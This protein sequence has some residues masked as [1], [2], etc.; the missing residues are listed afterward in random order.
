MLLHRPCANGLSVS[1]L[2]AA[3]STP[4]T[5]PANRS[6]VGLGPR[7]PTGIYQAQVGAKR[8]AAGGGGRGRAEGPAGRT[9]RGRPAGSYATRTATPLA[10]WLLSVAGG[11]PSRASSPHPGMWYGPKFCLPLP[12]RAQSWQSCRGAEVITTLAPF[13][14]TGRLRLTEARRFSQDHTARPPM[15]STPSLHPLPHQPEG[16]QERGSRVAEDP[17]IP[18]TGP[19]QEAG[20]PNRACE[21]PSCKVGR[22]G[23]R[24][25]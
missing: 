21:S 16:P 19:W 24:R 23:Q 3:Y 12:A 7:D 20:P 14:Q 15:L 18:G 5:S 25:S 11:Q 6:F 22:R 17:R 2:P 9:G 4:G 8:P 1:L 13:V 10:P